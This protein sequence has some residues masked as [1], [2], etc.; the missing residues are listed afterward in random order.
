MIEES[1]MSITIAGIKLFFWSCLIPAIYTLAVTTCG[2]N[3]WFPAL[4]DKENGMLSNDATKD[5]IATFFLGAG[6]VAS[7]AAIGNIMSIEHV[8]DE[9]LKE[10]Q[11]YAAPKFWGTKILVTLA[12]VQKILLGIIPPFSS[13]T[14]PRNNLMYASCLTVE[15]F[16]ISLLHLSAWNA[17]ENYYVSQDHSYIGEETPNVKSPGHKNPGNQPLLG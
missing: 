4:F 13:Y 17:H 1:M 16:F 6:F 14:V 3:N 11:F 7:L 10:M 12:F 8:Y 2:Y 9:V 5:Y 15:C